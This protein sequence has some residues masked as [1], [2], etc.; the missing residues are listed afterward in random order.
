MDAGGAPPQGCTAALVL[1]RGED[2]LVAPDSPGMRPPNDGTPQ[3][4]SE[5]LAIVNCRLILVTSTPADLSPSGGLKHLPLPIP[6]SIRRRGP[7]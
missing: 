2:P 3:D 6:P 4:G 5:G 1:W 7:L